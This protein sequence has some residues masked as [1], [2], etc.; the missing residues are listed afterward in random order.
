MKKRL[1]LFGAILLVLLFICL[2]IWLCRGPVI[3]Y[4]KDAL[5]DNEAA[6]TEVAKFYYGDYKNMNTGGEVVY[7]CPNTDK[8][9]KCYSVLNPHDIK[10]SDELYQSYLAVFDSYR[11]DKQD[12]E[13]IVVYDNFVA[14]GNVN[15]RAAVVYSVNG[16]KPKYV[17]TPKG[18]MYKKVNIISAIKITDNWYYTCYAYR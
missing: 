10:V 8:I 14:F 9:I 17:D 13:N 11:I 16:D 2:V 15:G 12:I 18:N 5:L 4:D 6:Y 3:S 7:S 1:K